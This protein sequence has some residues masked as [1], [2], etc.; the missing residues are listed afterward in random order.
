MLS[1][2][3]NPQLDQL[4]ALVPASDIIAP[5]AER[6]SCGDGRDEQS[7]MSI[8]GEEFQKSDPPLQLEHGENRAA[9]PHG[10]LI[11]T[12]DPSSVCSRLA[13]EP[14][15][16]VDT[17]GTF[18]TPS[19]VSI[20]ASLEP[21][22]QAGQIVLQ[23]E[24]A[25]QTLALEPGI[26]DMISASDMQQLPLDQDEWITSFFDN[27]Q[28]FDASVSLLTFPSGESSS[29]HLVQ[30]TGRTPLNFTP[31]FHD[32]GTFSLDILSDDEVN[33]ICWGSL[34]SQAAFSDSA[35]A[36]LSKLQEHSRFSRASSPHS[37]QDATRWLLTSPSLQKFD[38]DIINCF[39]SNFMRHIAPTFTSFVGFK[40][41]AGTTADKIL[42]MAAVG[43]LFCTTNGSFSLAR[44]MCSDARRMVSVYVCLCFLI[45]RG[46]NF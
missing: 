40:V 7:A 19:A 33:T 21:L 23:P 42:A 25:A 24:H 44:A 11:P 38:R 34:E 41:D 31:M 16:A 4:E 17:M 37:R 35:P 14:P 32:Y 3:S 10:S 29:C 12:N 6:Q 30:F 26:Q 15:C 1:Q 9:S 22:F 46:G 5:A 36:A 45:F 27:I 8:V 18:S 2:A 39:L 20:S 13:P 28:G 43:G